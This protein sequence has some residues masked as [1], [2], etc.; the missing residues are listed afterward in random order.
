VKEIDGQ[1]GRRAFLKKAGNEPEKE[2][3]EEIMELF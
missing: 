1:S 2:K 3:N